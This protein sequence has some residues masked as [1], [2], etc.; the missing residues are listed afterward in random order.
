MCGFA[1]ILQDNLRSNKFEE[2]L[3]KM[4]DQIRHRGP[5]DSGIWF[6]PEAGIGLS[7]RRL[8]ILDLSQQGHQP[9]ISSSGRFVIVF[10]GEVY[11]HR[12]LRKKLSRKGYRFRG[13]SDTEVILAA[14]EEW[15]LTNA[16]KKFI[17]MFAIA[18]WDY[19]EH[20]LF[21]LRDR[22]GI[23]PLYY[24]TIG[25]LFLFGSELKALRVHPNLRCEVNRNALALFLRHSYIP[26][27]Y[28]IYED[29]YKLPAGT[30][31]TVDPSKT[32]Q[33]EPEPYWS[34]H[35][36][37]ERS[38]QSNFD[39]SKEEATDLLEDLISSAV[40][41]RMIAD[42]PLG[43][44]LSGGIDSSTVVALMQKQSN[45]PVKTFA[46]G[47][48]EEG[49]NE[50]IYAKSVAR[51][52]GTDHTELYV[53][54]EQAM[55]VIPKLPALYDEP[56]SDSSQI[57]TFL[58]SEL[59]RKDVT[60]TL[61]GDGGDEFFGGYNRYFRLSYIYR[62]SRLFPR[63]FK[64]ILA[65]TIASIPSDMWTRLFRKLAVVLPIGT[66]YGIYGARLNKFAD[67]LR[68]DRLEDMYLKLISG[69]QSPNS[70]IKESGEPTEITKIHRLHTL[71]DHVQIMMYI[72]AMTYLPDDILVK[73]DRASMGV[74]L[75]TRVPLLDHRIA[76]F[77]W[78]I[79]MSMKIRN[80]KGKWILQE[81]LARYVPRELTE[82]PK[83]GFGIPIGT[84]LR[85]PLQDWA[86]D[87]L[88]ETRLDS[89]GFFYPEPIRKAWREHLAGRGNWT[90]RL[91]TILMFQAW[92]DS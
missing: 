72:D 4:G 36:I 41:L 2:I 59:A 7:F 61:S 15:G 49:Y 46:I 29:I 44:F 21:L 82:R 33:H 76:E 45:R 54:P 79:P 8:S 89:D 3:M 64:K 17:G 32:E 48:H 91:W 86:E 81:I 83:M 40:G 88:S 38:V 23:K 62:K 14:V 1:G 28:S 6:D 39:G 51:H 26:S 60:V 37:V 53:T 27:P 77:A 68:Q 56:F 65:G 67:I 10:N 35:S 13:N 43:A 74:S 80:R 66:T 19:H 87:L 69:W 71:S 22:I 52:L 24:G 58:V 20:K 85:G 9:M 11:N 12:E 75:E 47:F 90:A 42:V 31:L 84:W 70:I 73:V 63:L 55:S 78:Q 16:V 57:P 18:L 34:L 92:L 30:I 25:N 50:A 5:D